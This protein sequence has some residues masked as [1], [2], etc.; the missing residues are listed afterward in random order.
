MA[1][2][3]D[4][5]VIVKGA[6][7]IEE[8]SKLFPPSSAERWVHCLG[9]IVLSQGED[10]IETEDTKEGNAAHWVLEVMLKSYVRSVI[11]DGI[12][13]G[14]RLIGV[15]HPKNQVIVT[16][17]MFDAALTAYNIITQLVGDDH[18]RKL[19]LYI[20]QK[21]QLP[22]VDDEAWGT[23]DIVFYDIATNTLYVWDFKY[24][25]KSV[26]AFENKQL[27]MYAQGTVESTGKLDQLNVNLNLNIIQPRCYYDGIGPLRTWETCTDD[28]RAQMNIIR[29]ACGR[30]RAGKITCETGPWCYECPGRTKCLAITHVCASAIEYSGTPVPM[31][32]NNEALGYELQ[33]IDIAIDRLTQRKSAMTAEA[34]GRI[35]DGQFIPGR[36]MRD[37]YGNRK[38]NQGNSTVFMIGESF[39]LDFKQEEKPITVAQAETKLKA[40]KVDVKLL[41]PYYESPKTGVK[42]VADDNSKSRQIFSEYKFRQQMGVSK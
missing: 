25:H 21:I 1:T 18:Q 13:A 9:S 26:L 11:H 40:A 24:G 5:I 17:E 10:N 38:W 14:Q 3:S 19:Y 20:E 7:M 15:A 2:I 29:D 22:S 36:I 37:T 12:D 41:R 34:E 42:M 4:R 33:L 27:L 28:I 8:H 35:K 32:M 23:A 39:G 31:N 30:Y 6:G 16:E